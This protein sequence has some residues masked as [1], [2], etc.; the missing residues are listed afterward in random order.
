[1]NG[2]ERL[3]EE[4]VLAELLGFVPP[5]KT[6]GSRAVTVPPAARPFRV[7]A[8]G[9]RAQPIQAT[10]PSMA[11]TDRAEFKR[12]TLQLERDLLAQTHL[13]T[14]LIAASAATADHRQ[15]LRTVK[16]RIKRMERR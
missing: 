9:Q 7:C 1:M 15:R 11:G 5:A 6:P 2:Y 14:L 8:L 3:S 13:R 16:A 10:L 4:G 12:L